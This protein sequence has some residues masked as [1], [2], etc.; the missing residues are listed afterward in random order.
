MQPQYYHKINLVNPG[1]DNWTFTYTGQSGTAL[2]A[3]VP[4]GGSMVVFAQDSFTTTNQGVSETVSPANYNDP[5]GRSYESITVIRDHGYFLTEEKMPEMHAA[6][7]IC[8][9]LL[10][11]YLVDQVANIMLPVGRKG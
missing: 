1:L 7:L 2:T 4:A 8:G 10:G 9:L 11:V 3:N 6:W 5:Q